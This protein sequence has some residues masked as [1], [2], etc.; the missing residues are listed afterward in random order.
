MAETIR[1]FIILLAQLILILVIASVIFSPK[2]IVESVFAFSTYAEPVTL[3]NHLASVITTVSYA[4]GEATSSFKTSGVPY[5]VEIYKVGDTSYLS[6]DFSLV[7]QETNIRY[8]PIEAIPIIS[9]CEITDQKLVLTEGIIQEITVKKI[10]KNGDCLIYIV[11]EK[12]P[13]DFNVTVFPESGFVLNGSSTT[14]FVTVSLVDVK[15]SPG[16]IHLSALGEPDGV[17]ITFSKNDM[18]PEFDSEM[19]VYAGPSTTPGT[20]YITIM[21]KSDR[22]ARTALFILEVSP[23]YYTFVLNTEVNIAKLPLTG[24]EVNVSDDIKYT[25]KHNEFISNVVYGMI[26]KSYYYVDVED[27]FNSREFS[28]LRD[29]DCENS[30]QILDT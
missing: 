8:E 19:T 21:G 10:I 28:H 22:L 5:I 26:P 13:Y 20:Y 4:P 15:I 7:E 16:P 14:A 30:G 2:G 18:G 17:T 11:T 25:T 6:I 12:V 9:D 24:V 29:F 3:L 1:D 23:L 27:L